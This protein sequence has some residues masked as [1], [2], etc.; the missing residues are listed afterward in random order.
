MPKQTS[1][2]GGLCSST[3]DSWT[4]VLPRPAMVTLPLRKAG[5]RFLTPALVELGNNC[6]LGA[7]TGTASPS[8]ARRVRRAI[9]FKNMPRRD[10]SLL[11]SMPES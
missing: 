8:A 3:D 10:F 6:F 1:L 9:V 11:E 7:S 2:L 5:E 4:G